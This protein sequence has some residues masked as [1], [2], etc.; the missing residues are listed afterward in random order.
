M[1]LSPERRAHL[2]SIGRLGGLS[3]ASR[4]D[5]AAR[6]R[7]GQAALALSFANGHGC[8]LCPRID[9][10]PNLPERERARRAETLKTLHFTRLARQRRIRR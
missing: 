6:A 1:T 7:R 5:T 3:T 2:A 9:I 10:P 8:K 4:I